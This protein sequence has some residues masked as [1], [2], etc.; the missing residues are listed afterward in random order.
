MHLYLLNRARPIT[1]NGEILVFIEKECRDTICPRS[2][3]AQNLS[4]TW[5]LRA[6]LPCRTL[7]A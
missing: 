7:F 4:R 5:V 3:P 1:T 6:C 2:C